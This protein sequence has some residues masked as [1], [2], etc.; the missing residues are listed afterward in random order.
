MSFIQLLRTIGLGLTDF[1]NL[2]NIKV[3]IILNTIISLFIVDRGEYIIFVAA[4]KSHIIV[5]I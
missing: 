4:C 2:C 3:Y 5:N 1:R